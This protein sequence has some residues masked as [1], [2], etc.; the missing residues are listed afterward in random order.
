MIDLLCIPIE[1]F[2]SHQ[3]GLDVL[4][5]I[6][7]YIFLG[8]LHGGMHQ[9]LYWGIFP[10]FCYGDDRLLMELLPLSLFS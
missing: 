1:L 5:A 6:L 8:Y 9:L 2:S 10:L 3:D 4:V 7:G